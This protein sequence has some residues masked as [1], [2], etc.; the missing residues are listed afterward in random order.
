MFDLKGDDLTESGNL[1]LQ[2]MD[3]AGKQIGEQAPVEGAQFFAQPEASRQARLDIEAVRLAGIED[4]M[5]AK[6]E[7]QQRMLEEKGTQVGR[8]AEAFTN[9]DEEGFKVSGFWMGRPASRGSPGFPALDKRPIEQ[10]EEGAVV[11]DD[12]IMLKQSSQGSLVKDEGCRY[13][14]RGLLLLVYVFCYESSANGVLAL[15]RRIAKVL[16]QEKR[17]R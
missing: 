2:G 15:S 1:V 5:K 6:V 13:P 17:L 4:E 3:G 10:G 8:G 9:A 14:S 7:D 12:R 16:R 11:G